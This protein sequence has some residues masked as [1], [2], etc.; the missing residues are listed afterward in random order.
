MQ[1]RKEQSSFREKRKI[2]KNPSVGDSEGDKIENSKKIW[3]FI[4]TSEKRLILYFFN[5]EKQPIFKI[6]G[7]ETHLNEHLLFFV[8][9]KIRKYQHSRW[10]FAISKTQ[11]KTETRLK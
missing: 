11:F 2:E 6:S 10:R 4:F 9:Q 5:S 7:F 8:L 3:T 1:R